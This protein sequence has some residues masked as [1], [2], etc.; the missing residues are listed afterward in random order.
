M[1][2]DLGKVYY[3]SEILCSTWDVNEGLT[4]LHSLNFVPSSFETIP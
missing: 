4:S 2:P 1:V 3:Y